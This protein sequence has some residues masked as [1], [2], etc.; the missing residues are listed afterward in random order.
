MSTSKNAILSAIAKE[1]GFDKDDARLVVDIFLANIGRELAKSKRVK[2][3]QFGTLSM[4]DGGVVAFEAAPYLVR[5]AGMSE[6][7][8][9]IA[10]DVAEDMAERVRPAAERTP[11]AGAI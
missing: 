9:G 1:T 3:K 4:T 8:V 11:Q 7:L 2:I 6:V 10:E 5:N